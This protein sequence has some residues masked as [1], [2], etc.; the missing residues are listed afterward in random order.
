MSKFGTVLLKIIMVASFIGVF[1]FVGIAII[2]NQNISLE[3]YNHIYSSSKEVKFGVL[4]NKVQTNLKTEYDGTLDPY[5]SFVATAI[6][7]LNDS[8]NYYL[9]YLSNLK[10]ITKGE[11]DKLISLYD[12]YISSFNTANNYYKNYVDSYEN[13]KNLIDNGLDGAS[14]ARVDVKLKSLSF[15][16]EYYKC[17]NNGSKFFK[18]L[19]VLVQNNCFGGTSNIDYKKASILIEVGLVDSAYKDVYANMENKRKDETYEQNPLNIDKIDCFYD[20]LNLKDNFDDSLYLINSNFKTFVD[21]LKQLDVF[22][23]AGDFSNYL[24]SLPQ[25]KKQI[26]TSAKQFF[27]DNFRGE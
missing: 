26:A 9:D 14:Y 12:G 1:V 17:F 24:A 7:E 22:E 10:D 4:K 18:N 13:A 23:W 8:I 15:V 3:A 21:N 27:D 5:G 6:E 19:F 2:N 20:F 11:Q 16:E 25:A